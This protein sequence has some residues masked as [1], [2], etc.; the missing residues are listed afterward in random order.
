M[1]RINNVF[2]LMLILGLSLESA[3]S[4]DQE[5]VGGQSF[6]PRSISQESEAAS[7][8]GGQCPEP[9]AP[10]IF[11][12]SDSTAMNGGASASGG[13]DEPKVFCS[14]RPPQCVKVIFGC[15]I[16]ISKS[17][18]AL[19]GITSG[20]V[21]PIDEWRDKIDTSTPESIED[22]EEI[23]TFAH[24]LKHAEDFSEHGRG[25]IRSCESEENA[26]EEELQCIEDLIEKSPS[27]G[28]ENGYQ[29]LVKAL[30]LARD[31]N[32]CLCLD[33]PTTSETCSE[34]LAQC[35]AQDNSGDVRT[36][37]CSDIN[38]YCQQELSW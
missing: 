25:G 37:A 11:A 6:L 20:S 31:Y 4:N 8:T 30:Q 5:Q 14:E 16:Y 15:R 3:Y 13:C 32:A 35:E 2:L 26:F 33:D 10:H 17:A 1:K 7:L 38:G 23:C 29:P 27:L 9:P 28:E 21:L 24:E 12:T 19:L 34:C 22:V 18:C 36:G